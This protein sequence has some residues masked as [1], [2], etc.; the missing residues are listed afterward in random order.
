MIVGI[1]GT[2]SAGKSTVTQILKDAGCLVYDTD[3]MVHKYYEKNGILYD[4]IIDAFGDSILDAHQDINRSKLASLIFN[5]QKKL[6]NLESLV[7]PAVLKEMIEIAG[8]RD[9]L[10]F[11]EVPM[12][13]EAG[14][15]DF[16]DRIIGVDAKV[17][18]RIERALKKGLDQKDIKQ[19]M[20][21]QWQAKEIRLAVDYMIENN[22]NLE[23]LYDEVQDVLEIIKLERGRLW[24][25]K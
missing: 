21:R 25:Q 2:M 18:L 8:S 15:A 20:A 22:T 5:D 16:F 11:F 12:L 7:F 13:F 24:I 9:S 23:D 1:T 6:E 3:K 19:R 14:M 4:K 10:I 17:D